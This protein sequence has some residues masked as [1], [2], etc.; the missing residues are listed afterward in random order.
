MQRHL[1]RQQ[2]ARERLFAAGL[3]H[4]EEVGYAALR[5]TEHD[6]RQ[7]VERRQELHKQ[8]EGVVHGVGPLQKFR[9]R[10]V[11]AE[12]ATRAEPLDA[13]YHE[14]EQEDVLDRQGVAAFHPV[15]EYGRFVPPVPQE[16]HGVRELHEGV[17]SERGEGLRIQST[18]AQEHLDRVAREARLP[19][20]EE[21]A[22]RPGQERGKQRVLAVVE[23]PQRAVS[24]QV[25]RARLPQAQPLLERE[26][27]L[28]LDY[29]A[30]E[31]RHFEHAPPRAQPQPHHERELDAPFRR[32][33]RELVPPPE[34]AEEP[35]RE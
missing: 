24:R 11:V 1:A 22:H 31:L 30:V 13:A 7:L 34:V 3:D 17:A 9:V 4:L 27:V 20:V 19:Q 10:E 5:E 2:E 32:A 29:V 26:A 6:L 23:K 16:S 35:Y 18:E 14:R 28:R 15:A 25:G 21:D 12:G 33:G 8:V